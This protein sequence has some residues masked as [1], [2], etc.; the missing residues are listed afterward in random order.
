MIHNTIH[1]TNNFNIIRLLLAT[2]VL[3]FHLGLL[4]NLPHLALFNGG[5]AVQCFFTISGYLIFASYEKSKSL[6]EYCLKRA[7]RICPAVYF[8]TFLCVLVGTFLTILP[9]KEYIFSKDLFRFI[10]ANLAFVNF[11]H[12]HLPG[13]FTGNS[14]GAWVN[15]PLWS[16]KIEICFYAIVP[17]LLFCCR[18]KK[19]FG[20]ILATT[21]SLIY[22]LLCTKYS[23]YLES[24]FSSA[25]HKVIFGPD[26]SPLCTVSFFLCG[27]ILY[28]IK[29]KIAEAVKGRHIYISF[30]AL[31]IYALI[32]RGKINA[33]CTPPLLALSVIYACAYFPW[34]IKLPKQMGDLSYG[35]YIYHYPIIQ[36]FT[37]YSL[38]E[39]MNP[40][41]LCMSV[42]LLTFSCAFISWHLIEKRFLKTKYV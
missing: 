30:M 2:Q 20:L 21:L 39:Q 17:L 6:K 42:A 32:L 14:T 8:L 34:T 27:G 37:Q 29:D 41:T 7:R 13:V 11:I 24:K 1:N 3:I 36:I 40:L 25:I 4:F 31:L 26:Y 35:V 38:Q 18:K 16:L 22:Q 5:V 15:G 28:Y 12:P 23:S 33:Y 9:V 19:V 10:F